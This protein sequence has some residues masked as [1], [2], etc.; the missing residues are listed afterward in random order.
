MYPE[1]SESDIALP[2]PPS[3]FG[4]DPRAR[5]SLLAKLSIFLKPGS[6]NARYHAYV[7]VVFPSD[8]GVSARGEPEAWRLGLV[9]TRGIG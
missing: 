6:A 1:L 4:G 9:A 3:V 7:P 8:L 2:L 5:R